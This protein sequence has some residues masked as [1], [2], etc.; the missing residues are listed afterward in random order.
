[1]KEGSVTNLVLAATASDGV[2]P[3][4]AQQPAK[5]QR[6]GWDRNLPAYRHGCAQD[7]RTP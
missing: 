5:N 2:R 1:M 3:S 4:R 7:G 6:D